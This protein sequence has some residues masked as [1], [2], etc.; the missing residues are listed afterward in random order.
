MREVVDI[1]DSHKKWINVDPFDPNISIVMDGGRDL[2][3][4]IEDRRKLAEFISTRY[5]LTIEKLNSWIKRY[6]I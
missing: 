3:A 2:T 5:F 6:K 4:T 1:M